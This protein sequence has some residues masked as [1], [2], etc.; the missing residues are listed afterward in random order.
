MKTMGLRMQQST[1]NAQSIATFLQ[2]HPKI[3]QVYFP[4]LPEH[5]GHA[6]HM[7]QTENGG[8]VLSFEIAGADKA[9]L[10]TFIEALQLPIFAVSLGGVESILSHPATMS[11][12][13]L[14]A[15]E[16]A[17]QGVTDSLLRLSCGIEDTEDLIADL[18]QALAKI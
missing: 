13:C 1:Q 10:N 14:T 7:R 4:G 12:A 2:K 11:H 15:E 17:A 8:A 5:P 18:T 6:V 16:R 3:K 9:R